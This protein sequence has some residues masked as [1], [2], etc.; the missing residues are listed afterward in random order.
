MNQK[1][2]TIITLIVVV[3]GAVTVNELIIKSV[4]KDRNREVASSAERFV[5]EQIK[6]EQELARTVSK[7]ANSKTLLAAKPSVSEKFLYEALEGRY[8]AEVVDGKLLKISLMQ[9]QDAVDLKTD[10][11]LKKYSG[12]FKEAKTF[13]TAKLDAGTESVTLKNGDGQKIGLVTIR[14]NGEGRV[15]EIEIK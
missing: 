14:R 3:A 8:N 15:L 7:D 9:N 1:K 12:V 6:W 13:E 10:E 11:V 5:P 2:L 4:G